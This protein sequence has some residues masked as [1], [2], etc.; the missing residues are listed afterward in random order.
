MLRH[1]LPR[2]LV[3][4]QG[5]ATQPHRSLRAAWKVTPLQLPRFAS[6]TLPIPAGR[7]GDHPHA[8]TPQDRPH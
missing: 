5:L 7:P 2:G 8:L 4:Q 6:P 1:V 3:L